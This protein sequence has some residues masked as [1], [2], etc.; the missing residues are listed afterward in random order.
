MNPIPIRSH[1]DLEQFIGKELGVSD[2]I[3]ITQDKINLFADATLDHQWIHI[4]EERCKAESPFKATIAHRLFALIYT[5]L[6]MGTNCGCAKFEAYRK[7]W[8]RKIEVWSG[9]NG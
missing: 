8:Y 3:K 6:L 4:D 5:T 2:Y 9:S 1:A 7:L